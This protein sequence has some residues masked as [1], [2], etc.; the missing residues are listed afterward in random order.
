MVSRVAI[1][2]RARVRTLAVML[3]SLVIGCSDGV[4]PGPSSSRLATTFVIVVTDSVEQA[5]GGAYVLA[6]GWVGDSAVSLAAASPFGLSEVDGRAT[7]HWPEPPPVRYD[8]VTFLVP[9]MACRPYAAARLGLA[10]SSLHGQPGDSIERNLPLGLAEASPP[11]S[12]GA[13][14]CAGGERVSG[15][16]ELRLAIDSWPS[17][18]ADSVRARWDIYFRESTALYVDDAGGVLRGD[19]LLLH[20][21]INA[22]SLCA[23]G[24]LLRARLDGTRLGEASLD[25][26]DPG[27]PLCGPI[28]QP[29]HALRFVSLSDP[30]WP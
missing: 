9:A 10:A 27:H 30:F 5:V 28:V 19:S 16:F 29:I 25:A 17:T 24:Y 6:Q 20:L 12:S 4:E 7:F 26:L 21:R 3:A 1:E 11:L 18:A 15:A 2:D 23:P 14:V 22:P 13:R 8:S